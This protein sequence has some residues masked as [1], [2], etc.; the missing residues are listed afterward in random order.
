MGLTDEP[1]YKG[2]TEGEDTQIIVGTADL[3]LPDGKKI[4][5]PVY[6][7]DYHKS[8]YDMEGMISKTFSNVKKID[9]AVKDGSYRLAVGKPTT[10]LMFAEGETA[11]HT[12]P[13]FWADFKPTAEEHEAFQREFANTGV[14]LFMILTKENLREFVVNHD[15]NALVKKM[16]PM[17]AELRKRFKVEE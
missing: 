13:E 15:G 5:L 4:T 7:V 8:A 11:I 1:F 2:M 14:W 17:T 3:G 16:Q 6:I 9:L 10:A 12:A